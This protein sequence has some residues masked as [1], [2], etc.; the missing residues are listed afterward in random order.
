MET[1]Y[2]ISLDPMDRG[3]DNTK[4]FDNLVTCI[5]DR[6]ELEKNIFFLKLKTYLHHRQVKTNQIFRP[7]PFL[8]VNSDKS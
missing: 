1:L 4:H 6:S 5:L 8:G 7:Q 3:G 2:C